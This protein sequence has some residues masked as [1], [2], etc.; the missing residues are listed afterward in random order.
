MLSRIQKITF[1]ELLKRYLKSETFQH[2]PQF[3]CK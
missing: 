3:V 2:A 1:Y